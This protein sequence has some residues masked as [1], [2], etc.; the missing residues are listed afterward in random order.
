MNEPRPAL[1]TGFFPCQR[2]ALLRLP[3]RMRNVPILSVL[4]IL[5]ALAWPAA[6]RAQTGRVI[7]HSDVGDQGTSKEYGYVCLRFLRHSDGTCPTQW[8]LLTS[9]GPTGYLDVA[10]VGTAPTARRMPANK[11]YMILFRPKTPGAP[12]SMPV[13]VTVKVASK[14]VTTRYLRYDP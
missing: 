14:K 5:C 10:K 4:A 6:A 9:S 7:D 11:T 2:H 12:Y 1:A 3:L 8:A 13:N